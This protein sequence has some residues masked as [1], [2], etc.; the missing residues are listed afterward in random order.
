[1]GII[2]ESNRAEVLIRGILLQWEQLNKTAERRGGTGGKRPPQRF[3]SG[4]VSS[5][6][7]AP[8]VTVGVGGLERTEIDGLQREASPETDSPLKTTLNLPGMKGGYDT[9]AQIFEE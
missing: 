3:W 4:T 7:K 5:G 1:M 8:V 6:A 2:R 9:V